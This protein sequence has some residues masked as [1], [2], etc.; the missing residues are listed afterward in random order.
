M[1]EFLFV[2]K[3]EVT[4]NTRIYQIVNQKCNK[5]PTLTPH[6]IKDSN[7]GRYN[8]VVQLCDEV[9]HELPEGKSPKP[10]KL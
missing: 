2:N 8:T 5:A 10:N 4:W 3:I 7:L 6:R 1:I 9:P